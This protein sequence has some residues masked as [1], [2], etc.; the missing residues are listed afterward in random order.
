MVWLACD[1]ADESIDLFKNCG[2]STMALRVTD[3]SAGMA[4]K[5]DLLGARAR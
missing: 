2:V 3:A 1:C 4:P 5:E